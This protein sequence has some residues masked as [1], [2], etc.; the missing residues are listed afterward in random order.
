MSRALTVMLAVVFGIVLYLSAPKAA[1]FNLD[2]VLSAVSVLGLVAVGVIAS[3][4]RRQD[5]S[6]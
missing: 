2:L 6:G 4:R 5:R 3:R 1:W